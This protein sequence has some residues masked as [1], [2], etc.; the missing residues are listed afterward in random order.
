M[1]PLACVV[2]LPDIW[3][4]LELAETPHRVYFEGTADYISNATSLLV[5]Y[6]HGHSH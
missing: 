1:R 4:S 2:A 3:I 5:E 6:S